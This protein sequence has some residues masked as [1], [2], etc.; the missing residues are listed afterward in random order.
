M[1]HIWELCKQTNLSLSIIAPHIE[2]FVTKILRSSYTS[3]YLVSPS[4]IPTAQFNYLKY[5][6][7]HDEHET[8]KERWRND[9]LSKENRQNY[10]NT[11]PWHLKTIAYLIMS[12]LTLL[13]KK[14]KKK[15]HRL[16]RTWVGLFLFYLMTLIG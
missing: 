15:E 7:T 6:K 2:W 16:I 8:K 5:W 14:K 13:G 3:F 9:H 11:W 12:P 10:L 4:I 1:Q